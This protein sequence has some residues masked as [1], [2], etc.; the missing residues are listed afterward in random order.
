MSLLQK[1]RE[2]EDF[3]DNQLQQ[4]A[5]NPN[6]IYPQFAVVSEIKRRTDLRRIYKNQLAKQNQPTMTVADELMAEFSGQGVMPN[7]IS[8]QSINQQPMEQSVGLSGMAPTQQPS[9]MPMEPMQQNVRQM[10]GGG[11]IDNLMS[12]E[13]GMLGLLKNNP[14]LMF[15]LTGIAAKNNFRGSLLGELYNQ[16]KKKKDSGDDVGAAAL[17]SEIQN[18]EPMQM[19]A[20]KQIKL[21]KHEHAGPAAPIVGGLVWLGNLMRGASVARN[22]AGAAGTIPSS[23]A[24]VPYVAPAAS[25]RIKTGLSGMWNW[26]KRSPKWYNPAN[27][28]T[29]MNPA[30][31]I[32]LAGGLGTMVTGPARVFSYPLLGRGPTAPWRALGTFS[33]IPFL[34]PMGGGDDKKD[35]KVDGSPS[36][37]NKGLSELQNLLQVPAD[38]QPVDKQL[39]GQDLAKLGFAILASPNMQELG[40]NLYG[41]VDDMQKRGGTGLEQA[42]QQYYEAK[43]NQLEQELASKPFDDLITEYNAVQKAMETLVDA[44]EV[45][46]PAYLAATLHLNALAQQLA[47]RRNID[48]SDERLGL[49][50]GVKII[51]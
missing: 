30:G 41:M 39:Q 25:G 1:M 29:K 38:Y 35:D 18:Q 17:Q 10:A 24:L 45:E 48:L 51:D 15:G 8:P 12:G 9:M 46:G 23:R 32:P 27:L 13:Y 33:S 5:T 11:F 31:S 34:L 6:S 47:E 50:E 4:L 16:Y 2:L 19:A 43:V 37:K 28:L 42:Q 14:E 20:G 44:G 40:Q 22:V 21:K 3:S 36:P 49:P 7:N 26:L